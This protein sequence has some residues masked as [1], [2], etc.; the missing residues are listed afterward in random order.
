MDSTRESPVAVVTGAS[1]G[2][3]KAVFIALARSGQPAVGVS[4]TK[5]AGFDSAEPFFRSLEISG[6]E[7]AG[8]CCAICGV[9][10]PRADPSIDF[11]RR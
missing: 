10:R 1:Q 7:Q 11:V 4:R 6:P 3:G 9:S 8:S 5:P 2:I